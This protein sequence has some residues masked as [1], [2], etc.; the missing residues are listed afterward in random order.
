MLQDEG[1][2]LLLDALCEIDIVKEHLARRLADIY[3]LAE[4][5]ELY[6]ATEWLSPAPIKPP[7]GPNLCAHHD[8][9]TLTLGERRALARRAKPVL[10]EKLLVDPDP[11]VIKNLLNHPHLSE[12]EVVRV[13]A[14]RP[15]NPAV[16]EAIYQHKRWFARYAVKLAL[17]NNPQ[18]PPRLTLLILPHIAVPDL[19]DLAKGRRF[20]PGFLAQVLKLKGVVEPLPT[21]A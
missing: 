20:S 17:L 18:T 21:E 8:L 15:G 10:L 12:R 1:C 7:Q 11:A 14:K 5:E 9:S 4:R 16:L 13:A 3:A 2:L 6:L 19:L